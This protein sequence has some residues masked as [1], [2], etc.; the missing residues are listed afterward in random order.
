MRKK[1]EWEE[2]EIKALL[3]AVASLYYVAYIGFWWAQV[4]ISFYTEAVILSK[5]HL[6]DEWLNYTDQWRSGL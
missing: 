4:S 1:T 6:D 2:E 5:E 3:V